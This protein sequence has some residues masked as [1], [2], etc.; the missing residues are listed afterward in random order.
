MN[1]IGFSGLQYTV[2]PVNRTVWHEINQNISVQI[3]DLYPA[4]TKKRAIWIYLAKFYMGYI[5]EHLHH[6]N[7]AI[8]GYRKFNVLRNRIA[9]FRSDLNKCISFS[10]NQFCYDFV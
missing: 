4:A 9:I 8:F 10:G 6:I 3:L 7:A 1:D 2:N 5:I